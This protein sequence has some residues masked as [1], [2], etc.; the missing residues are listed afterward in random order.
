MARGFILKDNL[1]KDTLLKIASFGLLTVAA[2]SSPYF[3]HQLVKEYFK[4]NRKLAEKRARKIK[5]LQ[6]RKLVEFKKM[7]DGSVRVVLSQSGKFLTKLYQLE[8][9][10]IEKPQKWDGFWRILI[11]DIPNSKKNASL[12]FSRKIRSLG[13]YQ[14]QKSAWVYPYDFLPEIEFLCA[15][16]EINS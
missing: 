9:M 14:L 15:T 3:L 12:A 1:T 5:D 10:K 8:D 11:Y 2:I 16:F 7:A 6:K 4:D 13:L